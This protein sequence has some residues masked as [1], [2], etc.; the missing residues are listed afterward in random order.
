[1]IDCKW[2]VYAGANLERIWRGIGGRRAGRGML[3]KEGISCG[4]RGA[5]LVDH[6]H[7]VGLNERHFH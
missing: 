6:N 3:G 5:E 4:S 2:F 7:W 1:M